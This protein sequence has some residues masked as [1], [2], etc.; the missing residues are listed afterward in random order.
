[1]EII[2]HSGDILRHY[3]YRASKTRAYKLRRALYGGIIPVMVLLFGLYQ[4]WREVDYFYL[5]IYA[6]ISLLA[7]IL[8]PRY[9]KNSYQ[10]Y[11]TY[12]INK[13]FGPLL[14]KPE[15]IEITGEYITTKNAVS[16]SKV[17]ITAI[18]FLTEL[19]EHYIVSINDSAS[20]ILPKN[21]ESAEIVKIIQQRNNLTITDAT[22][23]KW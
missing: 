8:L 9:L 11:Y 2:H 10:R 17:L 18:Q 20:L 7:F 13:T 16:E 12:Y 22:K 23:W 6:I 21:A 5:I 14:D 1:M 19:K 3:L 15:T 4:S